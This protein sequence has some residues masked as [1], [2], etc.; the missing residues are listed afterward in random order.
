[1]R[2]RYLAAALMKAIVPLFAGPR[3]RMQFRASA[4]TLS[5]GA[6]RDLPAGTG[7]AGGNHVAQLQL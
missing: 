4:G 2:L 3:S 6:R 5:A 7:T 1:M